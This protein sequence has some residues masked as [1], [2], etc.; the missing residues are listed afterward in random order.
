MQYGF[1]RRLLVARLDVQESGAT[2]ADAMCQFEWDER[3]APSWPA[4]LERASSTTCGA[5]L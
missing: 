2:R 1:A 3:R 5:T 4:L